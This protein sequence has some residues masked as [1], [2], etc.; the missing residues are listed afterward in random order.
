M[1]RLQKEA[2]Q[3]Q[4]SSAS[5][6]YVSLTSPA[7]VSD[8]EGQALKAGGLVVSDS[9]LGHGKKDGKRQPSKNLP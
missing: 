8:D 3:S 2:E 6:S 9:K 1:R 4:K 5:G 7:Q